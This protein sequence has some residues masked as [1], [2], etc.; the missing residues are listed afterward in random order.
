[1]I[2]VSDTSVLCYLAILDLAD[3]LKRRFERVSIPREVVTEAMFPRA[4]APLQALLQS[5]PDWLIVESAPPLD[6][7]ALDRLDRGEAAAIRLAIHQRA[8][9]VLMDERLGRCVA[10]QVGL[11]VVGTLGLIAD[12][13]ER[14]WLDFDVAIKQLLS[15]TNFRVSTKVVAEVRQRILPQ[16]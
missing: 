14:E 3:I 16:R 7:P 12:A 1:M 11:R 5:L 10:E 15:K 4:P 6:L 9:F 13:A 2:V 8:D